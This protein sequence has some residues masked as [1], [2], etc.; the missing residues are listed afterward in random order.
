MIKK[1]PIQQVDKKLLLAL[2][3]EQ[4]DLQKPLG[5]FEAGRYYRIC[6]TA[7]QSEA[8]DTV[9]FAQVMQEFIGRVRTATE[10]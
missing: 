1:S 10:V 2:V 5:S 7:E 9:V 4:S 3:G 6:G 8:R